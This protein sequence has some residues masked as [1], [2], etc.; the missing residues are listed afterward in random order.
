MSMS[1]TLYQLLSTGLSGSAGR[2][3]NTG[4]QRVASLRL[5]T[6]GGTVLF[7]EE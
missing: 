5:T 7:T 3:H 1:K 4:D 2:E 6:G